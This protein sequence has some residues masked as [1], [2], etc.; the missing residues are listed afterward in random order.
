M[1]QERRGENFSL[2]QSLWETG[3]GKRALVFRKWQ[4]KRQPTGDAG[5]QTLIILS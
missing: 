5:V 1:G 4:N 2:V 3:P